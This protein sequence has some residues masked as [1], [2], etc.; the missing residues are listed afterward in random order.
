M[1]IENPQGVK[2]ETGLL[3]FSKTSGSELTNPQ[4]LHETPETGNDFEMR[5]V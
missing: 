4:E 5:R 2:E 3:L 1:T